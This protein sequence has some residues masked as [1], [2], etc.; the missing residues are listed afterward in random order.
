MRRVGSGKGSGMEET[1]ELILRSQCFV[2]ERLEEGVL[3]VREQGNAE[4]GGRKAQRYV[5]GAERGN[6]GKCSWNAKL[7]LFLLVNYII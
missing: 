1:S 3:N 6:S 7:R 5:L 4:C 2:S